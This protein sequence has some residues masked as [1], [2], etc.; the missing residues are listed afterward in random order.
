MEHL[1]VWCG[2]VPTTYDEGN[3]RTDLAAYVIVPTEV[4]FFQ[5]LIGKCTMSNQGGY[6][7]CVS[8]SFCVFVV[9]PLFFY[10]S[11]KEIGSPSTQKQMYGRLPSHELLSQEP[12]GLDS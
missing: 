2:S 6:R 8:I 10:T 4:F 11:P 5:D 1:Q 9:R 7:F 3:V 12:E